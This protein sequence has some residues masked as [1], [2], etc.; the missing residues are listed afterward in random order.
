MPDILPKK[1]FTSIQSK[2][3]LPPPSSTSILISSNV[4]EDA[5]T[6][7]DLSSIH[8]KTEIQADLNTDLLNTGLQ[9]TDL[10]NTDLLNDLNTDIWS[11][12][13]RSQGTV[14]LTDGHKYVGVISNVEKGYEGGSYYRY[15]LYTVCIYIYVYMEVMKTDI[16]NAYI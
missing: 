9:N 7:V 16:I 3:Q 6:N 1:K 15:Y 2:Y 12:W 5:D 10:I 14:P 11:L 13:F 8:L 4:H